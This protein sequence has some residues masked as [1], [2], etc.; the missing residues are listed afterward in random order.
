[1]PGGGTW[2][3]WSHC[4]TA[5]ERIKPKYTRDC[6]GIA[7]GGQWSFAPGFTVAAS[8]PKGTQSPEGAVAVGR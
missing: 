1:M 8:F 7:E 2:D 4:T 5:A 3:A 6:R